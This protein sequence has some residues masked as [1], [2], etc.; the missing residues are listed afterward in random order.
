LVAVAR[1]LAGVGDPQVK[2]DDVWYPGELACS[3][4]E[5]LFQTQAALYEHVTGQNVT[6]DEDKVL[7]S[8]LWRNTHY[9]HGEEGAEDLWGKGFRDGGDL[10]TREY[11]T[12]LFAHGFGLCGTTHSQWCAEAE[13][14]LGHCRGRGVGTQGHN[15]F[16]VFLTGGAYGAGQWALLDHDLSTVIFA[17]DGSRLLSIREVQ[18]RLAQLT[19][20]DYKP[21]KQH[22]W[23]VCGLHPGDGGVFGQFNVAE[24][25]AGYSGPPPI[26]H[27]R[28]GEKLRRYAEP[29]LEDGKTFAFWGR[30]YNTAGIPGP[31]RSL[32]W[33]NQPET[34][35]GGVKG[36]AGNSGQARYANAMYEYVPDFA[37]SDYREGVVS[38][39]ESSVTFEFQTPY[40]IAATPANN[41]AWAIY[42]KGCRNGL[43]L[44][45]NA[46]C[47]VA[48]SVDRG[49]NFTDCG[50]LISGMDL[51]DLVKGRRQYWLR[52][53]AAAKDLK[54]AGLKIVTV[55]QANA[56]VIPRLKE[57]GTTVTFEASGQGVIS[58]GPN[59]AQAESHVV[60]GKFGSPRVTLA[61]GTP[62]GERARRVY[63]AA[64]V[65]SGAPPQPDINYSIDV[66]A[67]EGRT[68]HSAVAD[69]R[70]T[71]LGE[72]PK[73]FWSQ[74]FCWGDQ[75]LA[76]DASKIQVRFR[77]TGGR[78]VLRAEAH[79][80]YDVASSDNTKVTFAWREEG[81][82]KS[83]SHEF[84]AARGK[85]I[86]WR[87]ETGKA[88]RTLW[89]EYEPVAR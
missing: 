33:V 63:A 47:D 37:N 42:E 77:N 76:G 1:C 24:Y 31:E 28:R 18:S 40:I 9:W 11:W 57:N 44:R 71:P 69:W 8:W 79:L 38:Q 46:E 65:A 4:F 45:G 72:Q 73:D 83:A 70:L 56:S 13:A 68:W 75:E 25:L 52:L 30:N 10:R 41:D 26:V 55:C 48:V 61:L 16:E 87:V 58:A 19:R 15:S 78:S 17:D 66:S 36:V 21:D 7:A 59:L 49:R 51:T 35:Y 29:G 34:L 43:V 5:R 80:L 62:R 39:D 22:G 6:T 67:D 89:V 81:A 20:R 3:T 32:T 14:L 86:T 88:P 84:E 12:G 27:L 64:H 23:P 53:G 82:V 2:T 74:S 54:S 50:P 60:D 85:P